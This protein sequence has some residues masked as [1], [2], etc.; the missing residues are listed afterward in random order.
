M[1]PIEKGFI[2]DKLMKYLKKI[3][4]ELTDE[5]DKVKKLFESLRFE[6]YTDESL[7]PKEFARKRYKRSFKDD[8]R[9]S[10]IDIKPK[11]N[12]PYQRRIY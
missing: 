11:R 6:A 8:I 2:V 7:S 3:F 4:Y 12:L 9:R 10:Q 1:I 5:F